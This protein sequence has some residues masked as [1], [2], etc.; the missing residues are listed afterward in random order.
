M[1]TRTSTTISTTLWPHA[2][3]TCPWRDQSKIGPPIP[4]WLV[5][6]EPQMLQ[7]WHTTT[8]RPKP[9]QLAQPGPWLER[10]RKMEYFGRYP[11]PRH[12]TPSRRQR[13]QTG[14]VDQLDFEIHCGKTLVSTL[15]RWHVT[16]S[17]DW[18]PIRRVPGWWVR[19]SIRVARHKWRSKRIA[20]V[21][22]S[23]RLS[24]PRCV[25]SCRQTNPR[26]KR[27]V[28]VVLM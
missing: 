24:S 3:T 17:S 13:D 19:S 14:P 1:K 6:C 21:G 27:Q 12:N 7:N 22:P 20:R 23:R 11:W 2:T 9:Q 10:N 5:D 26:P 15:D 28:F 4:F 18:Y 8:V 25:T 16:S